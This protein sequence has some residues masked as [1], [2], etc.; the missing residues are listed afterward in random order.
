MSTE[1]QKIRIVTDSV[2]D[3]PQDLLD[4]WNIVVIPCYVSYGGNSYAD[5]GEE[6]DRAEFY[7]SISSMQEFPKTAAPPPTIAEE[8]LREALEGYDKIVAI[9]VADNLS[10]TINNVRIASKSF[11]D[12]VVTVLDSKTVSMGIGWQVLVA[13]EVAAETGDIDAVIKA[14]EGVRNNNKLYAAI[15]TMEFLRRSGRV[16]AVVAS[17]G[18]FLK[19][20]PIITVEKDGE[21]VSVHRIRTFKKAKD[22]LAEILQEEG[23]LDRLAIIHTMDEQGAKEF[24]AEYGHLMPENTIITEVGP[25]LGTHIGINS[26][27]FVSVK[28][29]WDS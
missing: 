10:G 18:S 23:K 25:T 12:G 9:H 7:N 4:K 17:V 16:S 5:D 22:K 11:P 29:G 3:I 21:V 27:G 1:K 15:Y 28:S 24:K 14:V 8:I 13:C 20:K 26:I 6:L 19:I 2:A